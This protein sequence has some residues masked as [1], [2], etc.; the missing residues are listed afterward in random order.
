MIELH[1]TTQGIKVQE[2][3]RSILQSTTTGTSILDGKA[4]VPGWLKERVK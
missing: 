4:M 1:K 3:R 2:A